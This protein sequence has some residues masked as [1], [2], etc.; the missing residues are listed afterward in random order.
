MIA[1]AGSTLDT[2]YAAIRVHCGND[3]FTNILAFSTPRINV[4][5]DL[6]TFNN[7]ERIF[8]HYF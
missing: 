7:T 6:G 1:L 2:S 5:P 8:K 3:V 4:A